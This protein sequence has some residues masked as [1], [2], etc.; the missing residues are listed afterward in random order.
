MQLATQTE[1]NRVPHRWR[2]ILHEE[3]DGAS[4]GKRNMPGVRRKGAV[5]APFSFTYP[6]TSE[7]TS[8][9]QEQPLSVAQLWPFQHSLA[10]AYPGL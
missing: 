5:S 7:A 1:E 8:G 6:V 10:G 2:S 9:V 4:G 3:A